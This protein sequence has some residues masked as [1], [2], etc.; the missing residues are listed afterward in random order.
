MLN[1]SNTLYNEDNLYDML[2]DFENLEQQDWASKVA[3]YKP[4]PV[5]VKFKEVFL[6]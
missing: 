5:M 6:S 2:M 1:G 3:L 4:E